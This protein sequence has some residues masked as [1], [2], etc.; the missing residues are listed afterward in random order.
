[1][2]GE[3]SRDPARPRGAQED[4][5]Y[6]RAEEA[7]CQSSLRGVNSAK[8][9]QGSQKIKFMEGAAGRK[10]NSIGQGAHPGKVTY[11]LWKHTEGYT[12]CIWKSSVQLPP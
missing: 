8:V 11:G 9:R 12:Q 10:H 1:M 3:V 4:R 7:S 6:D 5:S 2:V